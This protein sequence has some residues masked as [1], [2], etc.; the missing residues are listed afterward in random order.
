MQAYTEMPQEVHQIKKQ[1]ANAQL[2]DLLTQTNN[3]LNQDSGSKNTFDVS[4]EK[5]NHVL[6]LFKSIDANQ[7]TEGAIEKKVRQSIL[8]K[9]KG[10]SQKNVSFKDQESSI[11]E[12]REN[13]QV[14]KV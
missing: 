9:A 13:I 14:A 1:E 2:A 11:L 3:Y 8:K 5:R 12:P 10:E 7:A 4:E 6:D